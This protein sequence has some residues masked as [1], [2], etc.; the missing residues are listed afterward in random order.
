MPDDREC[1][2]CRVLRRLIDAGVK[3]F[4]CKVSIQDGV[5]VKVKFHI[6]EKEQEIKI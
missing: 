6:E 1:K 2:I 4:D 3:N 5:I